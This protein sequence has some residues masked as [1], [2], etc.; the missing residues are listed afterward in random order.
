MFS[1]ILKTFVDWFVIRLDLIQIYF[2]IRKNL[3]QMT[4]RVKILIKNW[5][6]V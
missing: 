6:Y 2:Y 3:V 4:G 5:S 1:L